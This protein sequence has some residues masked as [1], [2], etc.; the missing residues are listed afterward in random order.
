LQTRSIDGIFLR[1]IT[2]KYSAVKH[3]TPDS[4]IRLLLRL[5]PVVLSV[6]ASFEVAHNQAEKSLL[7][8]SFLYLVYTEMREKTKKKTCCHEN[9][10]D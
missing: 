7:N 2:G 9:R 4:A 8:L 3:G 5:E 10:R 1:A 6:E